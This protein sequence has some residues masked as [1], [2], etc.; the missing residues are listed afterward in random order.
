[1]SLRIERCVKALQ[2]IVLIVGIHRAD[3][4]RIATLVGKR[5]GIAV[6]SALGQQQRV[7]NLHQVGQQLV[8]NVVLGMDEGGLHRWIDL[9]HLVA[10][11]IDRLASDVGSRSQHLG[12]AVGHLYLSRV[13]FLVGHLERT[14]AMLLHN[15]VHAV[16]NDAHG[17]GVFEDHI[18]RRTDEDVGLA[19]N[20]LLAARCLD[21]LGDVHI[22]VIGPRH[23][24]VGL[25]F[26]VKTI[27]NVAGLYRSCSASLSLR[28]SNHTIIDGS[29][30]TRLRFKGKS[31]C[32]T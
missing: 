28:R 23:V 29:S 32:G 7:A 26:K 20:P 6:G 9:H 8:L 2:T 13:A 10:H 30:L 19:A 18:L 27:L 5:L 31:Q 4:S 15:L 24:E 12:R 16:G 3:V 25:K 14:A 11:Q 22:V 1:M 17:H 21:A